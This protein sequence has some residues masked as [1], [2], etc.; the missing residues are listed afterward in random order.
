LES[1]QRH[2]KD[3]VASLI[4]GPDGGFA[5]RQAIKGETEALRNYV[6][7]VREYHECLAPGQ[8]LPERGTD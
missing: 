1:A 5:Y 8:R 6:R 3:V 4:D 2:V 7:I